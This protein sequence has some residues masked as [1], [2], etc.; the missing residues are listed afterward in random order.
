MSLKSPLFKTRFRGILKNIKA[1]STCVHCNEKTHKNN[2]KKK[3]IGLNVG[4]KLCSQCAVLRLAHIH[5]AK[6]TFNNR[7]WKKAFLINLI[8]NM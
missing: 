5:C 8:K 4:F 6:L 7:E 1:N 3:H 2:L